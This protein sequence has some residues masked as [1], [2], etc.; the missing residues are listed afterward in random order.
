MAD[1]TYDWEDWRDNHGKLKYVSPSCERITGYSAQEFI[2]NSNLIFD[3]I[4]PDDREL[5]K[6]HLDADFSSSNVLSI[7]FR[8]ISRDNK[9]RWI[10]HI[11]QPVYGDD[12]QFMGRRASNR[13]I[14]EQ[15]KAEEHFRK[16]VERESFLLELYKKAPQLADKELYNCALDLTV[17]LTDSTIGFFH[18]ISDDQKNVIITTWNNE[19]LNTCKASFKNH[20]PIEESGNWTDCVQAKRPLVYNDYENSPNRKGFPKGHTPVK[21]FISTPVFDEDKVKFIFGVGNKI[22]EYDDRDVIQIQSVANELYRIIKQ[23]HS[24]QALKEA[25]ENL[26]EKVEK[27]TA[28]IKEAYQLVKE[29]EIKLKETIKELERSNKELQSF[30]YITSHDLQ[31]PLRT[32][33]NYAGLIERRYKGTIG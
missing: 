27:R 14:T 4:H 11:C 28:E 19:A 23:R 6:K 15:K 33:G 24:A 12:G 32:I 18:M 25:H 22:E 21:R 16:E 17:S 30:A 3:I 31:E 8:I 20:Y 13:D 2:A 1:F 10:E 9:I 26:E 7:Q 29:N 5:F